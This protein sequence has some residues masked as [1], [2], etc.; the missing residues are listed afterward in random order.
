MLHEPFNISVCGDVS[1]G[2]TVAEIDFGQQPVASVFEDSD[3]WHIEIFPADAS[4]FPLD[5]F[6]CAVA[7]ARE[8][9]S[10]YVNRR[11]E[12]PPDGLSA[13]GFSFWLMQKSDGTVMEVRD[14]VS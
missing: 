6:L 12:N 11:G 9:L 8:R 2:Y 7:Y 13:A 1:K 14:G 5:A 10:L 3:G 4:S